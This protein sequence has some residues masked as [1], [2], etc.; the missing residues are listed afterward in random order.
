MER[1]LRSITVCILRIDSILE[2]FGIIF[3]ALFLAS[4]RPQTG[5]AFERCCIY[6]ERGLW[7]EASSFDEEGSE[8]AL[9][10]SPAWLL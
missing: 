1:G 7:V 4:L 2:S 9:P 3:K 5:A 8:V 6:S 10:G